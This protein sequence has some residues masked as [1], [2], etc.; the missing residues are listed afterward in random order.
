MADFFHPEL[1]PEPEISHPTD[2]ATNSSTPLPKNP[3]DP[4][5]RHGLSRTAYTAVAKRKH[6]F[7]PLLSGPLAVLSFPT[8]SPAHLKAALSILAPSAPDFRA[9]T[10]RA[11]PGY[12]DP[13][14]QGGLQ[15]LM[16][17]GVRV[18]GRVMDGDGARWV[19]GIDGGIDSLRVQVVAVLQDVGG[20]VVRSLDGMS[21]SVYW[22]LEGRRGMLE[23]Q[24]G[25]EGKEA[26]A[27]DQ[28]A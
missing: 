28:S 20:G 27:Q 10:R 21:R 3:L 16:L 17:L 12:Y 26:V 18:E 23:E 24:G 7:D 5:L 25:K 15:K 1:Q 14:V 9:P 2:P 19:G 6:A 13:A 4:S 11:N 8:V 22:T